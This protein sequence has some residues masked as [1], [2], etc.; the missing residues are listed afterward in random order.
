MPKVDPFSWHGNKRA[1]LCVE[2]KPVF[3]DVYLRRSGGY[4]I[5]APAP[6]PSSKSGASGLKAVLGAEE[7]NSASLA[8]SVFLDLFDIEGDTAAR[9]ESRDQCCDC[10]RSAEQRERGHLSFFFIKRH[11]GLRFG[12]GELGR[13]L[14]R[15]CPLPCSSCPSTEPRQSNAKLL[16]ARPRELWL[17]L[18]AW[19]RSKPTPRNAQ[20]AADARSYR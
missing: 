7:V 2:S 12:I 1:V 15:L 13:E 8:D 4:K 20:S 5:S 10:H 11:G 3:N 9:S 18:Y 17:L 6:V 19:S 16:Q 14:R